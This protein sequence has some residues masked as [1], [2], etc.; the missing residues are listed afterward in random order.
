M[1]KAPSV[2]LPNDEIF[3]YDWIAFR[4]LDLG[5]KLGSGSYGTV[6]RASWK[7]RTVAA[8][9]FFAKFIH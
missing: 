9:V 6:Y 5:K 8:K 4:D 7:G 2:A 1:S 3:F